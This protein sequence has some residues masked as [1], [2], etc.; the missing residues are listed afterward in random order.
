MNK[1]NPK[2]AGK[3]LKAAADA[4]EELCEQVKEASELVEKANKVAQL[5]KVIEELQQ[6]LGAKVAADPVKMAEEGIEPEEVTKVA[7]SIFGDDI[8]DSITES[9]GSDPVEDFNQFFSQFAD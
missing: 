5:E 9:P 1:L 6:K 3:L 4:I 2:F 8:I 7:S